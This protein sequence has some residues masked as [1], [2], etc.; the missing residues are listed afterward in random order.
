MVGSGMFIRFGIRRVMFRDDLECYQVEVCRRSGK[1]G[2]FSRWLPVGR[3]MGVDVGWP[4]LRGKTMGDSLLHV[5]RVID[6]S[7][8]LDLVL[9]PTIKLD[10]ETVRSNEDYSQSDIGRASSDLRFWRVSEF[11]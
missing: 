5:G 7:I 6:E 1:V 8:P 9:Y 10:L 3:E 2:S 4:A 11:R